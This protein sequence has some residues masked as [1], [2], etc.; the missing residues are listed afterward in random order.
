MKSFKDFS[1][2]RFEFDKLS[3]NCKVNEMDIFFWWNFREKPKIKYSIYDYQVN[4]LGIRDDRKYNK[5]N[6]K[7]NACI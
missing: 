6:W 2:Y 1:K 4:F 7:I 5:F 3:K